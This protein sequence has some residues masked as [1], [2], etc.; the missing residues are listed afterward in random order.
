VLIGLL[1]VPPGLLL[2]KRDGD[3]NGSQRDATLVGTVLAIVALTVISWPKLSREGLNGDGTE[4]YEIA[5]SLESHPLPRWDLERWEGP[6]RFGTPAVNPFLTNAYLAWSTMAVMGRGE[7]AARLPLVPAVVIAAVV[8]GGLAL[9]PRRSGWFYLAA[10]SAL[11]VLWNAYY[12]GYEPT[13]TD[14]AEPAATDTLMVALWLAGFAEIAAGALWIGVGSLWLAA[15]VLYSAPVLTLPALLFYGASE[16]RW[17]PLVMWCAT[18][19]VAVA[20]AVAYGMASGDLGDWIRQVRSEY[21]Y[22]LVDQTR[23]SATVPF[24]GRLVLLTGGLPLL[25]AVRWRRLPP[26]ARALVCSALVY[27]AIALF[28]SYKNLHYLAPLPF[29]LAPAALAASG[30]K[31]RAVA[32]AVVAAAFALSWPD[33]TAVHRET[34]EVGERSC[35]SGL[36]Y[37]EASLAGDVVYDAFARTGQAERFAVGKHTFIRYALERGGTE[38]LFRLSPSL[39]EGWTAVAGDRVVLAARDPD[40]Y[41]RWRLRRPPVPASPLF[42]QPARPVVRVVPDAW[43]RTIALGRPP[44]SALLIEDFD[45]RNAADPRARLLVPVP[46]GAG[47]RLAVRAPHPAFRLE[48]RVNGGA[49]VET[50]LAADAP[51]ADLG[52]AGWRRG[53]NVVEV[54][55]RPGGLVLDEVRTG[56]GLP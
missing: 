33:S 48:A 37:E 53:W 32:I 23:R 38:C 50:D 15:F 55:S 43:P 19:A 35:V 3:R 39:P 36:G 7:P 16:R 52:D 29:L 1:A 10:V 40:A 46:S 56:A 49:V 21:W 8:A 12:V 47:V 24:A 27:L 54:R 22:D 13:F 31:A 30:P 42:P 9:A 2:A 5:R 4:A 34:V 18:G 45:P 41:A 11:Y 26:P 17:R 20:A 14:L 25:A 28:S 44:G 6:G 51:E